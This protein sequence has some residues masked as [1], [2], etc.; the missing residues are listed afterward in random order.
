MFCWW[1]GGAGLT[2]YCTVES[3]PQKVKENTRVG[4]VRRVGVAA[5]RHSLRQ[6]QSRTNSPQT[7]H[8]SV[9][10][11]EEWGNGAAAP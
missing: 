11:W 4:A 3:S 9:L 2:A 8:S 1:S 7:R 10:V 5:A 6:S